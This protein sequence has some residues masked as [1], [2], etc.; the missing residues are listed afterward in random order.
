MGTLIGHKKAVFGAVMGDVFTCRRVVDMVRGAVANQLQA[1]GYQLVNQDADIM[2]TGNV[3]E[4]MVLTSVNITTWDAIGSLDVIMKI[5]PAALN[6][7]PITRR[8][9]A[10]HV[11][12]TVFGPSGKDFEQVMRAC[13]E[14]M[15]RQVTSDPDFARMVTGGT[16]KRTE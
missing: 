12:S 16:Q 2:V 6:D 14:D 7:A 11:A 10:K 9:R 1:M 4:F 15:Q 5:Q 8:F 13:L 3:E